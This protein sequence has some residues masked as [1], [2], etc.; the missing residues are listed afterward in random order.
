MLKRNKELKRKESG[1]KRLK[2][3]QK[4]NRRAN[5]VSALTM[6]SRPKQDPTLKK[7]EWKTIYE[8]GDE[9]SEGNKWFE[10]TLDYNGQNRMCLGKFNAKEFPYSKK[11]IFELDVSKLAGRYNANVYITV[12]RSNKYDPKVDYVDANNGREGRESIGRNCPEYDLVETVGNAGAACSLHCDLK[13][14]IGIKEVL[15]DADTS[16]LGVDKAG[17]DRGCQTTDFVSDSTVRTNNGIRGEWTNTKSGYVESDFKLDQ[18]GNRL[19]VELQFKKKGNEEVQSI[20]LTYSQI[21]ENREESEK[22]VV[23]L[24]SSEITSEGQFNNA[25]YKDDD[26][27]MKKYYDS[28]IKDI[29]DREFYVYSSVWIT[30]AVTETDSWYA[31][32]F[33]G[34]SKTGD[35]IGETAKIYYVT[36]EEE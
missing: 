5:K 28:F 7:V 8:S 20:K 26:S 31:C 14:L 25:V 29:N 27:T 9:I 24:D 1:I 35:G 11:L 30:G 6:R 33:D 10:G 15:K 2:D 13:D 16:I 36:E 22:K 4:I 12:P 17:A 21:N 3:L 23:M 19:R 34:F 18:K 32:K